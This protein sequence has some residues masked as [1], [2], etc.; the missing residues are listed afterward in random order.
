KTFLHMNFAPFAVQLLTC[1]LLLF[2]SAVMLCGQGIDTGPAINHKL[3]QIQ[4]TP[5]CLGVSGINEVLFP[6][7]VASTGTLGSLVQDI[8][9]GTQYILSNS[10]VLNPLMMG[11]VGNNIM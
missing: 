5:I 7:G 9:T 3:V 8:N 2:N 4:G 10:H 1:A 6:M 11:A